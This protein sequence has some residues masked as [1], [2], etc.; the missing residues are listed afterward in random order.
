MPS[1]FS[2]A[3]RLAE[4]AR[5]VP[6]VDSNLPL[7]TV[8][9]GGT[10]IPDEPKIAATMRVIRDPLGGRSNLQT[11][12]ANFAGQVGIELRGQSSMG[13][14]KKQYG[15]ETRDALGSD[16]QVSLLGMPAEEDWILQGPYRDK[17]MFRNAFAYELSNRIGRYAVRTRFVEAFVDETGTGTIEDH[18]VGL[19]VLME[20]IKRG[21]HRVDVQRLMGDV[22]PGVTGG[23]ILKIDKGSDPFFT[24]ERG[25][26]ILHVYP[27]GDTL[28]AAQRGWIKNYFDG[29]ESAL[30]TPGADYAAYIDVGSFVDYLIVNEVMKNIDAYRIST[31]MH[32]D[33]ES[34]LEMGPV[35]DFDLSST[36]VARY[37]GDRPDGWVILED[38]SMDP[39]KPPFWW[40]KLL[41][42][43]NFVQQF[44]ARWWVLRKNALRLSNLFALIDSW[45]TLLDEAQ[46]RNYERWPEAL[47]TTLGSEPVAFPTYAGEVQE[48]KTFLEARLNWIDENIYRLLPG[49]IVVGRPSFLRVHDVGTRYGPSGDSMDVEVVVKLDS[50]PQ[51]SFGFQLRPDADEASNRGML[52][53]LRD[54]FNRNQQVRLDYTA[55]RQTSHQLLRVIK[56]P[57]PGR[58][59][60]P[61]GAATVEWSR[62]PAAS[63]QEGLQVRS[64]QR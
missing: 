1:V 21:A 48:F 45:T 49:D 46:A 44:I 23:W 54:A 9:T 4:E 56:V 15:F 8:Q 5:E 16:L 43:E 42:D 17:V 12:P 31:Y 50:E 20:K 28:S 2:N 34:R 37:G 62:E 18:Y 57:G 53:A 35:W 40:E 3:H 19:F 36:T 32:K 38:F 27:D 14:P 63:A 59:R 10:P 64:E 24:T 6:F 11:T 60:K 30:E 29:F 25:T 47:E 51:K 13:Y 7:V 61:H 22:E 52:D 26:R 33:R 39:W 58:G 55:V 41:G